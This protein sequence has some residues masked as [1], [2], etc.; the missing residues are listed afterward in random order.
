MPYF[1]G[2]QIFSVTSFGKITLWVLFPRSE[3]CAGE[4]TYFEPCFLISKDRAKVERMEKKFKTIISLF[5]C[6]SILRSIVDLP[7]MVRKNYF[8][9]LLLVEACWS[10]WWYQ[11]WQLVLGG[12]GGHS[13]WWDTTLLMVRP[14]SAMN[15][16][17]GW[18]VYLYTYICNCE[19]EQW[20]SG[21]LLA[22]FIVIFL[23]MIFLAWFEVAIL[24]YGMVP[25]GANSYLN[26]R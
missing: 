23:V 9:S 4:Y 5:W 13:N 26:M 7:A 2:Q 12:D 6:V 21:L 3:E 8:S 11:A 19:T 16:L 20:F 10:H 24:F 15:V 14:S 17:F 22:E 18:Y 1:W 25:L